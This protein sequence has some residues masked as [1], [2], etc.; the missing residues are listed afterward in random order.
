MGVNS[1]KCRI[2]IVA[3]LENPQNT[4]ECSADL[5]KNIF[6]IPFHVY[7]LASLLRAGKKKQD[8][9]LCG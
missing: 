3:R 8:F 7:T 5:P 2:R 6:T 1:N 4:Q 9:L